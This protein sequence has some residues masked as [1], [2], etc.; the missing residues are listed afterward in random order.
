[1]DVTPDTH[2]E[3]NTNWQGQQVCGKREGGQEVRMCVCRGLGVLGEGV[4]ARS[5]LRLLSWMQPAAVN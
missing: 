5:S 3:G 1:M 4:T 2:S